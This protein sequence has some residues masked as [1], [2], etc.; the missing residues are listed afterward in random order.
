LN[1]L[2]RSGI[3]NILV[4]PCESM[5]VKAGSKYIIADGKTVF[6]QEDSLDH[7]PRIVRHV[8]R[9][10]NYIIDYKERWIEAKKRIYEDISKKYR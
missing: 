10:R 7:H 4:P 6:V 3:V 2:R 8:S 1:K 9:V 5:M